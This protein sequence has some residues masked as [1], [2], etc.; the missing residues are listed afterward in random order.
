KLV[1]GQSVTDACIHWDDTTAVL[2]GLAASVA[3]RGKRLAKTA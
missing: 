2:Q 3:Q 1:Y